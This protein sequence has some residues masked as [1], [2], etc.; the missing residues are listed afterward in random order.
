MN[1]TRVIDTEQA[2]A[3]YR[4]QSESNPLHEYEV[5]WVRVNGRGYFTCTCPAGQSGFSHCSQG[6]CKH[7]RAALAAEAVRKEEKARRSRFIVDGKPVD[8]E[9]WNRVENAKP[10]Q[11]TEEEIKRDQARYASSG[12]R[13]MK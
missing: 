6:T 8:D 2:T 3:Y 7:V 9:T 4:V 13:M 10:Y 12:F 1:C 11:W 5:R